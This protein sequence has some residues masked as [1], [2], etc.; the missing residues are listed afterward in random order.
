MNLPYHYI[1]T[2]DARDAAIAALKR[3]PVIGID[4]EGDSL[5]HY[6]EK[7]SL[8]QISGDGIHYIFD[9]LLLDTVLPLAAL[10]E[11]RSILKVLHGADYDLASLQRDFNFRVGPI[12]DTALAARVI[13]ITPCS[14]QNLYAHYFQ[15][16]LSKRYQKSDWSLRPLKPDQLDYAHQDTS[17]LI[18]LYEILKGEIKKKHREDFMEEE[19]LL[20]ET[21]TWNGKSFEPDDYLRIKGARALSERS[22]HVLRSL[23]VARDRLAKRY[24]RPPFKIISGNELLSMAKNLPKDEAELLKLFPEKNTAVY[25]NSAA[26]LAA[27]AEGLISRQQLP[28]RERGEPM[29]QKEKKIFVK[30]KSWR[31]S[32]A[33]SEGVEPALVVTTGQIKTIAVKAPTTLEGLQ[34]IPFIRKWQIQRYGEQWVREILSGG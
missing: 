24:D 5:Y 29:T 6:K 25:R 33:K 4:T 32:Q 12:F 27:I 8:I 1:T 26:W 28:K 3:C 13:G 23:A 10:F 17:H 9:P 7:V 22:Q 18:Q 31:D 11:S 34:E 19:C 21:I 20:M 30:L 15:I 14:L 2:P 16:V